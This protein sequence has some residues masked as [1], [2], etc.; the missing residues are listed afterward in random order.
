VLQIEKG[1]IY[2]AEAQVR[3]LGMMGPLMATNICTNRG[4]A[5]I[6]GCESISRMIQ[7]RLN[8]P[9]GWSPTDCAIAREAITWADELAK[10]QQEAVRRCRVC[11]CT[12][13]DCSGCIARTGEPCHWVEQDLCSACESEE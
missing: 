6:A 7:G 10:R 5:I 13:N 3:G 2:A 12:D 4:E 8:S 11:G 1:W 9:A